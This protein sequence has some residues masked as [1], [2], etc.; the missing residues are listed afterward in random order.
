MSYNWE[1]IFKDKSNKELYDIYLGNTNLPDFTIPFAKQEL[2]NR[3]FDFENIQENKDAWR[4]TQLINEEDNYASEVRG[5]K[6]DYISYKYYF[7]FVSAII[8]IFLILKSDKI[9]IVL[10]TI[11]MSTILLILNNYISI[12]QKKNKTKI[13]NE[14]FKLIEKLEKMGSLK[15]E[16]PIFQ[17]IERETKKNK[18]I[19]QILFFITTGLSLLIWII[20]KAIKHL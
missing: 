1:E 9:Y 18:N 15:N 4:L 2:I 5:K 10:L 7:L 16:S 12:K 19:L 3:D 6:L 20:I 14:K 8:I 17:D 13:K 11:L